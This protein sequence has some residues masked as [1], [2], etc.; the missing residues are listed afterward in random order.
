MT[1]STT[2]AARPGY[3]DQPDEVIT[4]VDAHDNETLWDTLTYK[5]PAALTMRTGS[6]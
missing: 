2:T 4:Y 5:L 1:P 6:G 3:A